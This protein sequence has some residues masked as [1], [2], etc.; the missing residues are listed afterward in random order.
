MCATNVLMPMNLNLSSKLSFLVSHN[1]QNSRVIRTLLVL[2]HL[3][4]LNTGLWGSSPGLE[5]MATF[6]VANSYYFRIRKYTIL[7]ESQ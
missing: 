7:T 4:G 3:L 1:G 6:T 2:G 5:N